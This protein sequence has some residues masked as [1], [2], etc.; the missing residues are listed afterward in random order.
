M[1]AA[2]RQ[3]AIIYVRVSSAAQVAK[4][5][6]AESQAARCAEFARMKGYEV[7]KTFEDK[8]V[9]GSLVDRPGMKALLA[10]LRQHRKE[11]I[12]VLIDD[13]SRL[14]RGLEAHLSLRAAIANAGGVLESPSIEFGEDSDSQLIEH[15]LASVSAH[16]RVKNAE[17]TRNRME[18]RIR[19]GYYPFA[20]PWGYKTEKREGHGQLLVRD[21]P[22]AS[23]IQQALEGYASGRFQTQAEVKRFLETQPD[24]PRTRFGTVTNETVNRILNR[25]I[26][27]G[28]VERPE[29]GVSLRPGK[30]EGL[31]DFATFEKIQQRLKGKSYAAARPDIRADFPL[32][33]SVECADCQRPLTAGWSTSKTGAKHAYYLCFNSACVS[34]RKSIPR[35]KIEG[36]FATLLDGLEPAPVLVRVAKAMLSDA[37]NIQR[38]NAAQIAR[39]IKQGIAKADSEVER[40]LE[41]IL[42][43][44]SSTVVAAYEKRIDELEREKLLL[45]ERGQ[46][47]GKPV[48]PFSEMFELAM[49][50]L[51]KPSNLWK[52]ERIEDRQTLIRLVFAGRLAYSRNEGFRT[53]Q[54]SSIFKALEAAKHGNFKMADLLGAGSNHLTDMLKEWNAVLQHSSLGCSQAQNTNERKDERAPRD[55]LPA[56][57]RRRKTA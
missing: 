2:T 27:A 52:S 5:Q 50:F 15:L 24:F 22:L 44:T 26:Y 32:R 51:A 21:E 49:G 10:Y 9:S 14:A 37:W 4:G 8:A 33:G 6:G 12:R 11:N 54:T 35:A 3:T 23:I 36:D 30:H 17:Q 25:V 29:W 28:M 1:N 41:R 57:G 34:H 45:R 40:L 7:I 56:V 42:S 16:A 20:P 46:N 47:A 43:A 55:G 48:R 38:R 39:A 13:I 19:S 53:P 31:I 18:A